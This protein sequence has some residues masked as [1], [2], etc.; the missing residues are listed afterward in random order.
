LNEKLVTP[1]I[2]PYTSGEVIRNNK[3]IIKK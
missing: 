3:I 1:E 2:N